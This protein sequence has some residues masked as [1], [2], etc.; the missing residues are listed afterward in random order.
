[1]DVWCC[2][3]QY[4]TSSQVTSSA[5]L[6]VLVA[7]VGLPLVPSVCERTLGPRPVS[8]CN[9]DG[10]NNENGKICHHLQ[11]IVQMRLWYKWSGTRPLLSLSHAGDSTSDCAKGEFRRADHH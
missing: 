5:I 8:V 9:D 4:G 10:A 2:C 11:S 6:L 1:M 3:W 7:F